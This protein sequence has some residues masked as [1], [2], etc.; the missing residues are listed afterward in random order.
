MEQSVKELKKFG[1]SRLSRRWR[2][3]AVQS[4]RVMIRL[5]RTSTRSSNIARCDELVKH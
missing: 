5:D 4:S 1:M 2:R 3:V